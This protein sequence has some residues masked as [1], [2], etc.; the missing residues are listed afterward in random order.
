MRAWSLLMIGSFPSREA[1]AMHFDVT[2]QT[3][4]NWFVGQHRPYGDKVA[5]AALSL[6]RFA[7]IMGQA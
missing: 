5:H 4:C 2:F 1:C 3:A 7:E 6:P